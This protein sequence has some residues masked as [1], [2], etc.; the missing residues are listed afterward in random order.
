MSSVRRLRTSATDPLRIDALPWP[1]GGALLGLTLCPG[2]SDPDG[3]FARWARDLEADADAVRAW[4]AVAVVSLLTADELLTLG[5]PALGA[6]MEARGVEWH[7]APIADGCAPG[8]AFERRWRLLRQRLGAHLDGGRRVLLHC[9]GGLGRAGTVAARLLVE[10][11]GLA[12]DPAIRAVRAAR[13]GAIETPA[14]EEHLRACAAVSPQVLR[15]DSRLLGCLLGGALGDAFGHAVEPQSLQMIRTRHGPDGLLDPVLRGG[16][17]LVSDATQM[18]LFTLE[19]LLRA[20]EAGAEDP[21]PWL[22]E[23]YL[24][25][26]LTQQPGSPSRW[27]FAPHGALALAP[28]LQACRA[29]GMTCLSALAAGGHGTGACPPNQSK[30]CGPVT[31]AAP[32]GFGIAPAAG[33]A[34]RTSRSAAAGLAARASAITHGH[35]ETLAAAAV[36]AGAVHSLV[37]SAKPPAPAGAAGPPLGGAIIVA[38]RV[39]R[40]WAR[41]PL[42]GALLD[43]A[44]A[45]ARQEGVS[46]AGRAAR[47]ALLGEG[48]AAEEALAIAAFAAL[49]GCDFKQAVRIAANHGGDSG[50]T[51]ALAGNLR[52]AHC[53][54]AEL[55]HA[56]VERLD[57]LEP[58]LGLAA[59]A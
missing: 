30:D 3:L 14:Q 5:V 1:R 12:P 35:P 18:V 9:K 20:R 51:A 11:A 50:S 58:L 40:E 59:R 22:R 45:L 23:A 47:L 7:H 38:R 26:W 8:P 32:F 17:L 24:D 34:S 2:R 44:A 55:P 43:C 57:V 31:R 25:W 29:P 49:A 33:S 41:A 21:L 53:G 15:R 6:A 42:T 19:G 10:W 48:R 52:G 56:W 27:P 4:G 46:P 37:A 54:V 28:A 16:Q 36:V 13:P 39:A